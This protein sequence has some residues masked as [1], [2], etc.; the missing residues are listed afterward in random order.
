MVNR[1]FTLGGYHF[2][3]HLP[4]SSTER[5]VWTIIVRRTT[6]DI[7]VAYEEIPLMHPPVFGPDVEDVDTLNARVEEIIKD[8]GLK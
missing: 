7:R 3:A 5:S 6:D 8:L 4:G 2:E 1:E